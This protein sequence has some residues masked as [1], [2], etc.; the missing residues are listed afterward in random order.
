M[1]RDP[2]IIWGGGGLEPRGSVIRG[3][4]TA[5]RPTSHD[6]MSNVRSMSY[7]QSGKISFSTMSNVCLE[8]FFT[9][10]DVLVWIEEAKR[11]M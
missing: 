3:L 4:P 5:R 7:V 8:F 2:R 6:L 11:H 10:I 1:I 9:T